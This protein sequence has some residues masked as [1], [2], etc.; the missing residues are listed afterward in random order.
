MKNAF[1]TQPVV[2]VTNNLTQEPRSQNELKSR[3]IVLTPIKAPVNEESKGTKKKTT[4]SD[5][6]TVADTESILRAST[7]GEDHIC[8]Q[9]ADN[10]N[11]ERKGIEHFNPYR[12][13]KEK[14]NDVSHS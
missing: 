8:L 6:E 11:K 1:Q 9:P 4:L 5:L 10:H 13:H 3:E 2:V 12:P 7:H 14:Q